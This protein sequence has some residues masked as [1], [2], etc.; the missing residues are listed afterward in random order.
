MNS[1]EENPLNMVPDPY[2]GKA[3]VLPPTMCTNERRL[4]FRRMNEILGFLYVTTFSYGECGKNLEKSIPKLPFGDKTDIRI[5]SKDGMFIVTPAR[6]IVAMTKGGIDILV[7]QVFIMTYGSFETYLFQLFDRSYP[8][9]GLSENTLDVSMDILM[10]KKWDGKFCKM[11]DV[12]G[13]NYKSSDLLLHFNDL[14]MDF[15]GQKIK[16]PLTFLD[17]LA[18]IRH[19]IVHA[20]SILDT[21][22]LVFITISFCHEFFYFFSLLTG[23]L[24]GLFSRRFSYPMTNIQPAKA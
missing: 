24:D 3:F 13:V 20:S 1:S 15:D 4:F 23:Y 22:N 8:S 6:Q 5:E 9:I 7:R 19:R 2:D 11:R 21:G 18:Q 14:A 12:F 17:E 10:R 16:N